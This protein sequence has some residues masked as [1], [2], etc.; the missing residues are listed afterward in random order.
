M[1]ICTLLSI[2]LTSILAL[3]GTRV[4]N[5][6]ELSITV[7]DIRAATGTVQLSVANSEAAWNNQAKPIA[8]KVVAVTDKQVV[9]HFTLPAGSYAVQVMHDENGNNKL[10]TNF[11][12][13]PIEGYGFSNN[14]TALRKANYDEARFELGEQPAAITIRLR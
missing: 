10:D 11:V 3:F 1:K 4:T 8:G 2:I 5:A 14:P 6:G 7:T 9:L 13:M 12:G